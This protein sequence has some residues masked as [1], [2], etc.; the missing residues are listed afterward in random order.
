MKFNTKNYKFILTSVLLAVIF[1]LSFQI[2]S[3]SS[4][5]QRIKYDEANINHMKYGLFNINLWKEKLNK[6]IVSEIEKFEFS[7]SDKKTLKNQIRAQ[8]DKLIDKVDSHIR[9]T[10]SKSAVGWLKQQFLDAFVDVD[11]LKEGIP[12]YTSTIVSEL[13]KNGNQ[14]MFKDAISKRIQEYMSE[15]FKD[16]ETAE[17]KSIVTRTGKK[18]K[19][20]AAAYLEK[21]VKAGNKKLFTKAWCLLALALLLFAICTLS[22]GPL[23][24]LEFLTIVTLM[25]TLL[26]VSVLTP[27][28]DMDAKIMNFGFKLIGHSVNF[29]DQTVYFQSKSILDV[30]IILIKNPDIPTKLV[31]VLMISFSIFFPAIKL[32]SSI[33]YYF[34]YKNLRSNRLI[35]FFVLKSSKWSMADVQVVAI[36][37]AYIGFNGMITTQFDSIQKTIPKFEFV[38]TNGTSLQI[39]FYLFVTYV[40][41]ALIFAKLIAKNNLGLEKPT[42]S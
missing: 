7:K 12:G 41:L 26:V 18:D 39:G 15:T 19:A 37:M 40:I 42:G 34:N 28:I 16:M 14:Q 20:E 36:T 9:K 6:I 31:G 27:M 29:S 17:I 13:S 22:K 33:F 30:F 32:L 1:A 2:V 38:S 24:T 10:N 35:Q 5:Q 3:D 8:L 4:H 23:N 21:Q 25:G 11:D